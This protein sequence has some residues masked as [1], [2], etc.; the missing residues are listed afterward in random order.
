MHSKSLNIFGTLSHSSIRIVIFTPY[1]LSPHTPGD[2]DG[3]DCECK[4][5][6][7]KVASSVSGGCGWPIRVLL[8]AL[9]ISSLPARMENLVSPFGWPYTSGGWLAVTFSQVSESMLVCVMDVF[10]W[11]LKR[12]FGPPRSSRRSWALQTGWYIGVEW[13]AFCLRDPL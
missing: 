12:R 13:D 1:S 5:Y 8:K 9:R 2:R 11:S 7:W 4:D 3:Y 6:S 10:N